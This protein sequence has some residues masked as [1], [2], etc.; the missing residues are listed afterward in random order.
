MS[1]LG[2]KNSTAAGL[3]LAV[4]AAVLLAA[5]VAEAAPRLPTV[6][7]PNHGQASPDARFVA[8]RNQLPCCG[9]PASIAP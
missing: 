3:R 5:V 2:A 6:F 1:D 8:R 4:L 7:E 9:S